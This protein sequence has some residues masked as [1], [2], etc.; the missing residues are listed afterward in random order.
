MFLLVRELESVVSSGALVVV[1]APLQVQA[2]CKP[3]AQVH[4]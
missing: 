1:T 4:R 2:K 3:S